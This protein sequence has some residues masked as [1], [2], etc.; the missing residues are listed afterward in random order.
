MQYET[1]KLN[2]QGSQVSMLGWDELTHFSE[3]QFFYMLSRNR[4]TCGVKPYVRATCNPDADS[5]V[6]ELIAWWIDQE[7]GFPIAERA[8]KLRWVLRLGDVLT[9]ADSAAELEA[10]H[11]G[12]PP[13]SVTFVPARLH[14][15]PA[16]MAK[17]PGYLA[18][19]M[20]LPPVDR[21]RLLDGNWKV[22]ATAGKVFN[23]A[24]FEIVEAAPAR[25]VECRFWDFAGTERQL[26]KQDP[27]FTASVK[28]RRCVDGL[29]YVLDCTAEQVGPAGA[30]TQLCNLSRQDA[31]TATAAGASYRVRWEIEP[32][33]AAVRY[34]QQLV[35]RLAGLDA[36][37][38]R[39]SGDKLV[40]AKALAAQAQAGNVK[41]LRGPWN[42]GWLRH[43]HGQPDLPHDDILDASTGAFN[44]LLE[45]RGEA[46][47][48]SYRG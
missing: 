41:L 22:R 20:A 28:M 7:T 5:W 6:A 37:G 8:G 1:T 10:R 43:M 24:W 33:A 18:N 39:S 32:G 44:E 19:L 16:L 40:R 25:G 38:V 35:N 14:D 11:P 13:K 15:N 48:R 2:W 42:E 23:R 47:G 27:D 9:W 17:D 30:E 29:F 36:G 12:I 21:G 31:A 45:A 3:S 34:T 4:S 26:A 46:K